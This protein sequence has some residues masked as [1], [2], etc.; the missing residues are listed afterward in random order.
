M[1]RNLLRP[2][3]Q[4]FLFLG[5]CRA[6]RE[7]IT[8]T[9]KETESSFD[10]FEIEIIYLFPRIQFLIIPLKSHNNPSI[11]KNNIVKNLIKKE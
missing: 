1:R 2:F 4:E 5:L 6:K 10:S 7:I 11:I 9:R 3:R 8:K